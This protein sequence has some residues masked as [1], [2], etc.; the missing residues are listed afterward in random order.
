MEGFRG[1]MELSKVTKQESARNG[2][3][4]LSLCLGLLSPIVIILMR[5]EARRKKCLSYVSMTELAFNLV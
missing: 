1:V 2:I 5:E 3:K 4:L